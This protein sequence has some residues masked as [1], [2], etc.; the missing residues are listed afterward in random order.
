MKGRTLTVCVWQLFATL[1]LAYI[2][3]H[4]PDLFFRPPDTFSYWLADLYGVQNGEDLRNL[5]VIYVLVVSFAVILFFTLA[6]LFWIKMLK[7]S[8]S[9]R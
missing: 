2:W 4:N 1:T 9:E 6:A 3:L 8:S 7:K 5:E